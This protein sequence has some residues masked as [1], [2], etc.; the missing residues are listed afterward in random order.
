MERHLYHERVNKAVKQLSL[1]RSI[2]SSV[3][4]N[5]VIPS[6]FC[7]RRQEQKNEQTREIGLVTKFSSS[8]VDIQGVHYL[9]S[10]NHHLSRLQSPR[11]YS[12]CNSRGDQRRPEAT[13]GCV[14][15]VE[16]GNP[17]LETTSPQRAARQH[18]LMQAV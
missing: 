1:L 10:S 11:Q 18:Q 13:G 2:H 12:N 15:N 8:L 17:Y 4:V 7:I 3:G 16:M 9:L 14:C 6:V 5:C